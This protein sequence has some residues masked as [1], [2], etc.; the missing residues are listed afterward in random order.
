MNFWINYYDLI[1]I[2]I[3]LTFV[4]ILDMSQA[5][6]SL[7]ILDRLIA[8][9][10]ANTGGEKLL[11]QEVLGQK[12]EKKEVKTVQQKDNAVTFTKEE[13]VK[14]KKEVVKKKKEAGGKPGKKGEAEKKKL[15]QG[16]DPDILVFSDVDLRVSEIVDCWKVLYDLTKHPDSD[17]LFCEKILVGKELRQIASGLQGQ[18]KLEEMKGKCIVMANLRARSMG[19]F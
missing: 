15:P 14:E 6:K 1:V 13:T 5:P 12:M 16:A 18:Y 4:I 17:Y 3:S 2:R 8:R 11:P 7:A 9:L 19:G 10:E